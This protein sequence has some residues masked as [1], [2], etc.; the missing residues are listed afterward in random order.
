MN[1]SDVL[2]F[3]KMEMLMDIDKTNT[4]DCFA[5]VGLTEPNGNKKGIKTAVRQ[6]ECLLFEDEVYKDYTDVFLTKPPRS[7]FLPSKKLCRTM[8]KSV[9]Q[10][11][12][13]KEKFLLKFGL[14]E[15]AVVWESM[16]TPL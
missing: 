4:I 14:I 9:L 8:I 16:L 12:I 11:K 5:Q 7:I 2:S 3:I 15:R 6:M 10:C 1:F 13:S